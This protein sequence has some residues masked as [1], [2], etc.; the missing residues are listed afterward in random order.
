MGSGA[1]SLPFLCIQFINNLKEKNGVR[2]CL[3][4]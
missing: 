4:L 2:S 1:M 3:S